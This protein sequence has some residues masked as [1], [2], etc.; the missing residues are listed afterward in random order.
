MARRVGGGPLS[1]GQAIALLTTYGEN[2]M[3]HEAAVCVVDVVPVVVAMKDWE[4]RAIDRA[5]PIGGDVQHERD[6]RIDLDLS[7]AAILGDAKGSNGG[8]IGGDG[9]KA[10]SVGAG[11]TAHPPIIGEG[12]LVDISPEARIGVRNTVQARGPENKR[13]LKGMVSDRGKAINS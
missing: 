5:K 11:A 8:P 7:L 12:I 9:A 1:T 10:G 4:L 3:G 2:F 6:E 13:F